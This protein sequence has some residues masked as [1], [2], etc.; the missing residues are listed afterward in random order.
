V[1]P[2]DAK[3]SVP[4]PRAGAVSRCELVETARSSG[5]R[6]VAVT[7]PA[8]YG[9]SEFL[10]EWAA[11]E[12]RPVAWLSLDRFDDHPAILLASLASAYRRAGLGSGDLGSDLRGQGPPVLSRAAALLAAQFRS[13]T[14]PFVLMLDDL[15]QLRSPACQDVLSLVTS[16]IPHGSQ[17]AAASRYEQAELPRLRAAADALEMGASDLALDAAGARQ[18]FAS[19]RVS[20]D[21]EQAAALTELT[22]G[23]PAGLY[24][25]ALIAGQSHGQAAALTGEDRFIADYLHRE[26]LGRQPKAIQRFL[27]RTAVLDQLCAPLCE[28]VLRTSVAAVQLR[29]VEARSLFLTPLDRER[30]WYRYHRLFREFLLGELRRTEPDIAAT[31]HQRAADW[32][33]SNDHPELAVEHLLQTAERDRT[34]HLVTRLTP[35]AYRAGQL[36]TVQRWYRA[37]GDE[38]A[39]RYPPLAVLRCWESLLTG[40]TAGAARWADVVETA[41]F[42]GLP[43]DGTASFD[44]ARAMLR[45]AM[46]TG[47]PQPMMA[48]AAFAVGQEHAWSQWRDNALW[49]LGEAELLAGHPAESRPLFADASASAA[50]AGHYDTF[51]V[52]ES[53][54]AWLEMDCGQWQEAAVRLKG[55]LATIEENGIHAYV[56]SI[57][58]FAAAARLA[59]HHSDLKE[60]HRQLTQAMR[61]RP[62]ATYLLP[63]LAVRLRLQL[64]RAYH[65]LA[66]TGTARQLLHEIDDIVIHRPDLGALSAEVDE[67]RLVLR[68][69]GGS[70]V[71]LTPAELRLLPYL[72][73]HLTADMIAKQLFISS[74][75]VKTEVKAIYRKLGVS[76]R[77]DAVQKATAIGL[78]GG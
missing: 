5:C 21:P 15:H 26:A 25:A 16:A 63:Y 66:D 36:P 33:E 9:K 35:P 1:L 30:E 7:A 2:L 27:R 58:A 73:T 29:Q 8:G 78:L 44:S 38:G 39:G 46:C 37:V 42:D 65:A 70:P 74:H 51:T 41:S 13:C 53:Q 24:L 32:Y 19:A 55:A 40:D 47:G 31:L 17:L 67:F 22:E 64:A 56:T 52:C 69:S 4:R 60:A 43:A 34:V 76:S 68:S 62:V 71:P 14:V 59:L 75:T 57:P 3:F 20:V 48:D 49:L 12:D 18:I 45:A 61:A 77:H 50:R 10:A 11:S 54:L 28:A 6:L 72:Q 23:W